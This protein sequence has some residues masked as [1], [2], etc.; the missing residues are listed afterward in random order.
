MK[1]NTRAIKF[2]FRSTYEGSREFMGRFDLPVPKELLNVEPGDDGIEGR[3]RLQVKNFAF[4]D[5]KYY[6]IEEYKEMSRC[7]L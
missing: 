5:G 2:I 6:L 1:S 7:R 4:I 3:F